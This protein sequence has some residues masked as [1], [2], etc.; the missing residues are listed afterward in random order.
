VTKSIDSEIAIVK[1]GKEKVVLVIV[2][3]DIVL[4]D[5]LCTY[6]RAFR[7]NCII[8]P[9]CMHHENPDAVPLWSHSI[10][11]PCP[12]RLRWLQHQG[13]KGAHIW[14]TNKIPRTSNA[15][16]L[17]HLRMPRDQRCLQGAGMLSALNWLLPSHW[18]VHASSS[19]KGKTTLK[20]YH[21]GMLV[22]AGQYSSVLFLRFLA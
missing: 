16:T 7:S 15:D 13:T 1:H 9:Q 8:W 5:I 20:N 3:V 4:V 6:P 12:K 11:Y 14:E 10:S 18:L 17:L 21:Y 22:I 19:L 2:Q